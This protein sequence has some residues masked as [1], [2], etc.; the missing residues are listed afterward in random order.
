M[1]VPDNSYLSG[2]THDVSFAVAGVVCDGNDTTGSRCS[3][4]CVERIWLDERSCCRVASRDCF[5]SLSMN[6]LTKI[7]RFDRITDKNA[8]NFA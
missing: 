1:R 8:S 7:S 4:A 3:F 2:V 6:I 5:D